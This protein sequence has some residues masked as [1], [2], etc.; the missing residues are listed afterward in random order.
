MWG[1]PSKSGELYELLIKT[2][3]GIGFEQ[4]TI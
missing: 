2:Q 1:V 4:F 3:Y